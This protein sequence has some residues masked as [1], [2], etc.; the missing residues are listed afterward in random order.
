MSTQPQDPTNPNDQTS[1]HP[2]QNNWSALTPPIVLGKLDPPDEYYGVRDYDQL[3]DAA[4]NVYIDRKGVALRDIPFLP[5][6]ISSKVEGW[7]LE[8]W[9]K[10]STDLCYNDIWQRQPTWVPELNQKINNVANMARLRLGRK[11]YNGRCW[12]NNYRNRPGKDLVKTVERLTPQQIRYNTTWI[13]TPQGVHPP[14]NPGHLVPLDSFMNPGE[15]P[16]QHVASHAVQDAIALRGELSAKAAQKGLNRWDELPI[17]DMPHDW[18]ARQR[19]KRARAADRGLQQSPHTPSTQSFSGGPSQGSAAS[20]A[21]GTDAAYEKSKRRKVVTKEQKAGKKAGKNAGSGSQTTGLAPL[22][23]QG[24]QTQQATQTPPPNQPAVLT[25]QPTQPTM[26]SLRPT[27]PTMLAPPYTQPTM[28]APPYTQPPMMVPWPDDAQYNQENDFQGGQP[29]QG[30]QGYQ[31]VNYPPGMEDGQFVPGPIV[32]DPPFMQYA[33]NTQMRP[34]GQGNQ[35]YQG[36]QNPQYIPDLSSPFLIT[37]QGDQGFQ[38]QQAQGIQGTQGYQH[39][40]YIP[41]YSNP[42]LRGGFQPHRQ[43]GVPRYLGNQPPQL[44]NTYG[45]MHGYPLMQPSQMARLQ[46]Q[47]NPYLAYGPVAGAG[48]GFGQGLTDL[49]APTNTQ[50]SLPQP[51]E[52][53]QG[54]NAGEETGVQ[55]HAGEPQGGD[56]GDEAA[57]QEHTGQAQEG[58][59]GDDNADWEDFVSLFDDDI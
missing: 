19:G 48:A 15:Q 5:R 7:R 1:P 45:G 34:Q 6:F 38:P 32:P 35:G 41:D 43:V 28:M 30:L 17:E 40:R 4:G 11:P 31:T 52:E 33:G 23:Q 9:F 18:S 57:G 59:T 56:T 3:K 58:D 55:E 51:I 16:G 21:P 37:N 36:Y 25:L 50:G 2:N 10:T 12:S 44:A 39:P 20:P 27:R 54:G 53:P 22:G 29:A 8:A 42:F 47:E 49:S 26:L 46:Q 14:N 24:S 13:I